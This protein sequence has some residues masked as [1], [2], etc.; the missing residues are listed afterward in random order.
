[1]V[2]KKKW[3]VIRAIL[4]SL[5]NG[6]TRFVACQAAGINDGTLWRW[7]RKDERLVVLIDN[8]MESRIK[9]VEDA[10]FKSAL[11]GSV[12]AQQYFLNNRARK[13]WQQA[14]DIVINTGDDNSK[15][16]TQVFQT[17]PARIVFDEGEGDRKIGSEE[18]VPED[19]SATPADFMQTVPR[20][21]LKECL[22]TTQH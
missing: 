14:P 3:R 21:G 8:V 10:V 5:S 1:M 15:H 9:F 22:E 7:E 18:S 13:K 19:C 11:K 12:S 6:S 16:L 17:A 4:K 20:E 2:T